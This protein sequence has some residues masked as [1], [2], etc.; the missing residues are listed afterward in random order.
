MRY[1]IYFSLIMCTLVGALVGYRWGVYRA[2][3]DAWEEQKYQIV[4]AAITPKQSVPA[5]LPMPA[6]Y[7]VPP[8]H[9][10]QLDVHYDTVWL[11]EGDRLVD[12]WITDYTSKIDSVILKDNQ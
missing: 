11:Y 3:S 2:T 12:S 9:D 5:S 7:S 8:I 6:S 4:K 10:Y 1:L